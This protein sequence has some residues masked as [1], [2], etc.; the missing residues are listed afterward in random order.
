MFEDYVLTR[1]NMQR[2]YANKLIRT[3]RISEALFE[4]ESNGWF[5]WKPRRTS[6][7]ARR[8]N[9][10]RSRRRGDRPS[11]AESAILDYVAGLDAGRPEPDPTLRVRRLEDS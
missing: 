8:G 10:W 5:P 2:N 9:W 7:S 4:Q 11:A 3:W 1:W 6:T